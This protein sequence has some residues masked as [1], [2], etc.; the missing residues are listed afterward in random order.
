MADFFLDPQKFQE[1]IDSFQSGADLIKEIKYKLDKKDLKLQSIDRYMECVEEFNQ[2]VQLFNE[3]MNQD[4]KSMRFIKAKWMN[5]DSEIA[6]KTL[7]E[8]LFD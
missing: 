4:A 6:T 2:T 3:M 1:Q 8:I 5:A 7:K